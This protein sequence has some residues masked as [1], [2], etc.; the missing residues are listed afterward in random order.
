MA[1]PRIA[2][3][4]PPFSDAVQG[5]LERLMPPGLPP[6][7]LFATLARSE[8][9]FARFMAAGLLDKGPLPMRDREIMIDRT[10]AR[11]GSEYEW[12]VHIA[13]FAERVGFSKDEVAATTAPGVDVVWSA[14][15]RLIIQLADELHDT[16]TI[17]AGLW[18]ALKA[19]F[20]DEQILE[21][22]L[23]AGFYHTVAYLTNG[24]M[25]PLEAYAARFPSKNVG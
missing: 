25:L 11:T 15:E 13:L 20:S 22:I 6:L 12:G 17:G 5:T 10:C 8:R 9:A 23:L 4:E 16:S 18:P 7:V 14:R 1:E 19:E 24:L 21:L 3:A 2:P